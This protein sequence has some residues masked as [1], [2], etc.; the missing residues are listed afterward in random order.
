MLFNYYNITEINILLRTLSIV[1]DWTSTHRYN[2]QRIQE[3]R[4]VIYQEFVYCICNQQVCNISL[5]LY[6]YLHIKL[7]HECRGVSEGG[8]STI[9]LLPKTS[10][11]DISMNIKNSNLPLTSSLQKCFYL[12]LL[13]QLTSWKMKHML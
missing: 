9:Q 3:Q 7:F 6:T 8:R 12:T 2:K 10:Y 1:F 11:E 4:R 13:L 5:L